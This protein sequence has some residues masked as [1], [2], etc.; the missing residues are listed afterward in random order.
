MLR[1]CFFFGH[2]HFVPEEASENITLFAPSSHALQ[3]L[4]ITM[5]QIQC[6]NSYH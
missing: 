2:L 1:P 3:S 6:Q 5:K 4:P